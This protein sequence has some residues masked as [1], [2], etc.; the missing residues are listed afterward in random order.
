MTSRP[1]FALG[2]AALAA[3][4][5][6]FASLPV[7]AQGAKWESMPMMQLERLYR[8]PLQDTVVQRWRDPV[9]GTVCYLYIPISAQHSPPNETGYVQYGP[10]AIGSI[11]CVR[12]EK[13]AIATQSKAP[14]ATASPK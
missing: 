1:S 2:L 5:E 4:A 12:A 6:I 11:S 14:P 7:S 13:P 9:D 3:V 10:N 8:G